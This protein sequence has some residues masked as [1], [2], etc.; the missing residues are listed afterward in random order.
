MKEKGVHYFRIYSA[1]RLKFRTSKID[2]LSK[3]YLMIKG[4]KKRS[5]EGDR[6]KVISSEIEGFESFHILCYGGIN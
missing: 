2:N 5:F 6:I 1:N 3:V 4:I